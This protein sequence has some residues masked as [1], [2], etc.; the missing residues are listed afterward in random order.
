MSYEIV[1]KIRI[2]NNEVFMTSDSNNVFPKYY[3]ECK[4]TYL[5]ELL[6]EKGME[7]LNIY[8]LKSYEQGIMQKGNPNKW[9]NAIDRLRATDEYQKY[10]WRKSTYKDDCPIRQTRDNEDAYNKLLLSS[11]QLKEDKKY[12]LKNSHYSNEVYVLRVTN[13]LVKYTG[14]KAKSKIFKFKYDA[15]HLIQMFDFLELIEI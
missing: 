15:E 3:V 10:D 11:L 12:I 7:A 8:L 13:R 1:K 2:E 9:S 14:L 4:N 5:T 6:Q